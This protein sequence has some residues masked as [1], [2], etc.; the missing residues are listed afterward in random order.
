M[1]KFFETARVLSKLVTTPELS[2]MFSSVATNLASWEQN[3]YLRAK[4]NSTREQEFLDQQKKLE[5]VRQA[6]AD[7]LEAFKDLVKQYNFYTDPEVL[8]ANPALQQ[9]LANFTSLVQ[10][11]QLFLEQG[12]LYKI[13]LETRQLHDSDY[14]KPS[15]VSRAEAKDEQKPQAPKEQQH[16]RVSREQQKSRLSN[17]EP[18]ELGFTLEELELIKQF[19]LN[20]GSQL[21]AVKTLDVTAG[22]APPTS[23]TNPEVDPEAN[24]EVDS[25]V[26]PTPNQ[27]TNPTPYQTPNQTTDKKTN[28]EDLYVQEVVAVEF[29]PIFDLESTRGY[30]LESQASSADDVMASIWEKLFNLSSQLES[31]YLLA[32]SFYQQQQLQAL[33]PEAGESLALSELATSACKVS[34]DIN[35]Y[36]ERCVSQQK[37]L[38]ALTRELVKS[39]TP[40]RKGPFRILGEFIDAEW[41]SDL[42]YRRMQS[43]INSQ[44]PARVLDVGSGNGYFGW[45]MLLSG[46]VEQVWMVEPY[47]LF[48]NQ[49]QLMSILGEFAVWKRHLTLVNEQMHSLE[50]LC[51]TLTS[52]TTS[53]FTATTK[54]FNF[55]Q[56]DKNLGASLLNF[57]RLNQEAPQQAPYLIPLPANLI[58]ACPVFDMVVCMGV[59]YHRKDPLVFLEELKAFKKPQPQASILFETIV[60]PNG[61]GNLIPADSY[62]GMSNVYSIPDSQ[63]LEAL[64]AKAKYREIQLVN[65]NV[66]S[67]LEQRATKLSSPISLINFIDVKTNL[68]KEGYYR[69]IRNLY[70]LK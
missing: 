28:L 44:R 13:T 54:L 9:K 60:A 24:L 23:N 11:L 14:L 16:P 25:E 12:K 42:K 56:E 29:L 1:T 27:T 53:T 7:C 66:T 3:L 20:F 19:D 58:Q 59:L 21:D 52:P 30:P 46:A 32:E 4:Q 36:L 8:K 41:R 65:T 55:Y 47:E 15:E 43:L 64:F 45:R 57:Q 70:L 50:V 51:T 61:A 35:K 67:P 68:T 31:D 22:L 26:N 48:M 37:R 40:W 62:A 39:L 34:A 2:P 18:E 17:D 5:L 38:K 49:H 33:N 63:Q 69:P 6:S 10:K